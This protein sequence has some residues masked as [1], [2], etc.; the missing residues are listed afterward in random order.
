MYGK[1]ALV[2]KLESAL[3]KFNMT[4][5][6]SEVPPHREF[7]RATVNKNFL[8]IKANADRLQYVSA[9]SR[10]T[11]ITLDSQTIINPNTV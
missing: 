3:L 2:H 5:Y 4:D 9:K 6:R 11:Q 8:H 10:Q 1:P 7:Q